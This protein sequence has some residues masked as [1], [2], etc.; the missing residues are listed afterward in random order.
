MAFTFFFRDMQILELIIKHALPALAGRS[1][2]RIWDAGCAMGQETYSLAIMLAENMGHFS[3]ANVHIHATDVEE[4]SSFGDTVRSGVYDEDDLKRIPPLLLDKYFVPIEEGA[5]FKAIDS[6]RA[7]ITYTRHDL[8]SL[9]APGNGF[10]LILCKN[11]LLHFHEEQRVQVIRMFHESLISGGYLAT[12]QTQ[13]IP[14][15]AR[16]SF[17][18]VAPDGQVFRKGGEGLMVGN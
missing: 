16:C 18:K 2:I 9:Q 4:N 1:R 10:S 7:R 3:F 17:V 15:G 14:E 12:E 6:I 5:R 11:V 8:L 13:K